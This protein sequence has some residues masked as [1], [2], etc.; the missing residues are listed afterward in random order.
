VV[1][2][3]AARGDF[4]LGVGGC[5]DTSGAGARATP[6][7]F[8][9]GAEE[10][11]RALAGKRADRVARRRLGNKVGGRTYSSMVSRRNLWSQSAMITS[12]RDIGTADEK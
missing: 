10:V 9:V 5:T 11:G 6:V 7:V 1:T 4:P 3:V 2:T 8:L 12:N